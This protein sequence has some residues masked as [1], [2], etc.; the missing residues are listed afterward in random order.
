MP[1][2]DNK[3]GGLLSTAGSIIGGLGT[4]GGWLGIG[5]G[6][7]DRRQIKQQTKLNEVNEATA[8]RMADYEQELK[9]KM[10]KDTNYNAILGE[11][12]KAGVSKA[13]AIGG[14]VGGTT[15]ASVGSVGGGSAAD[16]ASTTN[17]RVAQQQQAMQL[18]SQIALQ[19]AQKNNLDANT[20]K[21]LSELPVNEGKARDLNA[22]AGLKEFQNKLNESIGVTRLTQQAVSVGQKLEAEGGKAWD[23]YN[24]WKAAAFENFEGAEDSPNSP[25][26][27]AIK[28]GFKQQEVELQKAVAEK[29]LTKAKAIV[30]KFEANMAEQGLAPKS[31]WYVKFVADLLGRVGLNPLEK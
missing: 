4:I 17:A 26:A 28:A 16:A 24:A 5:E 2:K 23:E 31:P 9:M 11:A 20:K 8:K 27:K 6:R 12:Q 19:G 30:E 21:T 10:W 13:A 25:I 18:G 15:G 7:Q 29:D 3:G 22:G 14:S 1:N